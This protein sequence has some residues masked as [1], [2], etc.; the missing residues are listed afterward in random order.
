MLRQNRF[1]LPAR[2]GELTE[3]DYA[4]IS[5]IFEAQYRKL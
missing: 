2:Y 3:D 1:Y 4:E 5:Q